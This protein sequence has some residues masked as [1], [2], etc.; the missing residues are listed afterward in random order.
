MLEVRGLHKS[1]GA[2]EVLK[3]IDLAVRKGELVFVIGPSGSGKS[4]L[5]RCC[6]RLEEPSSGSIRVEGVDVMAPGTDINAV[7]R[8]IG[9]VFQS[10]NLYPHLDALGNVTLALRKVV[11][12][13]RAEAE[14]AGQQ[15]LARVGLAEKAKSF[16]N[17]LSGGQQQRVAIARA[18]ALEPAILLFDEPTSALDPELVGSVLAVMRELRESGMTMV[19]VSHEMRFARSAADRVI[20]MDHGL[21][22][23]QG[24]PEKL[25]NAP[26]H[27]R[28]RDFIASIEH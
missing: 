5:L 4:T 10:F 26:E 12:Q 9:M 19:V 11:G 27:P 15:A 23:E 2:L 21:I 7:R 28:I 24:T 17:E 6:N 1:F 16:P 18:L 14:R 8:R 13:P 25:F 22:V 3:G 20:F